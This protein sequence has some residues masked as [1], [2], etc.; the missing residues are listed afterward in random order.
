MLTRQFYHKR[1]ATALGRIEPVN[2]SDCSVSKT[3]TAAHIVINYNRAMSLTRFTLVTAFAIVALL[4]AESAEA[5]RCKNRIIRDGM[6]EQQVIAL[7]GEPTTRRHLGYATR[8]VSYGWRRDYPGG[9]TRRQYPGGSTLIEEVVI[10][11]MVYNFG[12]RKFMRR[13]VFEGGV[14]TSIESIGY[15]YRED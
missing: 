11:E 7:C 3:F 4:A 6:H 1:T 13:L 15:G 14:L 9:Y 12:P 10:T 5:F 2:A 8:G